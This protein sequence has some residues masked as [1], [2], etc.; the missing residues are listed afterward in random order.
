MI[1]ICAE[2]AQALT[3]RRGTS[4]TMSVSAVTA[5]AV[6]GSYTIIDAD[7][8]RADRGEIASSSVSRMTRSTRS[9]R[10]GGSRDLSAAEAMPM[11]RRGQARKAAWSNGCLARG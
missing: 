7:A 6:A 5:R 1:L 2:L 4:A 10:A 8:R 9:L 3:Y 11:A